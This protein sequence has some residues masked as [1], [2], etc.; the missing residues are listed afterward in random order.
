M[1]EIEM[2]EKKKQAQETALSLFLDQGPNHLSCTESVMFCG[3]LLMGNDTDLTSIGKYMGGGVARMGEVCGCVTGVPLALGVR[4][5]LVHRDPPFSF[6]ET[7]KDIQRFMR[8]FAKE[9]GTVTCRGL[10]G[11]GDNSSPEAFEAAKRNGALKRCPNF[12][13]FACKQLTEMLER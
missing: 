3:R 9:F 12:V 7:R 13:T 11:C 5:F 1:C 8:E 2:N 10:L 6:E 4:D